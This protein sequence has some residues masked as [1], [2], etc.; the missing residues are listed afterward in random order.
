MSHAELLCKGLSEYSSIYE[1]VTYQT[2]KDG[3]EVDINGLKLFPE[4]IL[5][6]KIPYYAGVNIIASDMKS[7]NH[8]GKVTF[9]TLKTLLSWARQASKDLC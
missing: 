1:E 7:T 3:Q 5:D 9:A 2:I 6:Y 4:L 8:S